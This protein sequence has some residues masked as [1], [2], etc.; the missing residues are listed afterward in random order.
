MNVS[1]ISFGKIYCTKDEL[2]IEDYVFAYV[3]G[4]ENGEVGFSV[5]DYAAGNPDFSNCGIFWVR[6]HDFIKLFEVYNDM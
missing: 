6:P 4:W 5:L 1:E 2:N 3:R